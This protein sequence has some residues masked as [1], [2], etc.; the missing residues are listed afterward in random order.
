MQTFISS[1]LRRARSFFRR[2]RRDTDS[3][4]A[5]LRSVGDDDRALPTQKR[6]VLVHVLPLV[7]FV[8][9]CVLLVL[10]IRV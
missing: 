1:Q 2:E 8:V 3:Q 5:M 6:R 10:A 4:S 9:C 7:V